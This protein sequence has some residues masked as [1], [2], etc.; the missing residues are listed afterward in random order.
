MPNKSLAFDAIERRV[1]NEKSVIAWS[2]TTAYNEEAKADITTVE[3]NFVDETTVLRV[4]LNAN[5]LLEL[6]AA[7]EMIDNYFLQKLTRS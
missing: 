4:E 1:E 3:I 7:I 5:N 6:Q 2:F